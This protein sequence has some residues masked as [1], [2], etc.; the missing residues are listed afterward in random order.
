[1]DVKG[2]SGILVDGTVENAKFQKQTEEL[3]KFQKTLEDASEAAKEEDDKLK[4]M[5]NEFEKYFLQQVYKSMKKTVN[6][7]KFLINGGQ[8]EEIFSEML[9]EKYIDAAV[10]QGG[11]GLAQKLYEQLKSPASQMGSEEIKINTEAKGN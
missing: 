6:Y 11:V 7:D 3:N 1:M 9:E 10:A 2:I 5:C 4:E 8:S